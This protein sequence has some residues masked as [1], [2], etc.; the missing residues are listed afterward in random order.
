M[1][2]RC[3]QFLGGLTVYN[4]LTDEPVIVAAC[5]ANIGELTGKCAQVSQLLKVF[6]T[7]ERHHIETL[8]GTPDELL[9]EVGALQVDID[10]RHP[11]FCRDRRKHVKQFFFF[12]CHN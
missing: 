2:G 9:V 5:A 4:V 11:L 10:F 8:V 1:T 7:I 12:L 6:C 3:V